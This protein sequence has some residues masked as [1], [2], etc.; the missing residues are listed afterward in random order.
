MTILELI[1]R[2]RL[3]VEHSLLWVLAALLI[4]FLILFK[5]SIDVLAQRLDIGYAPSLIVAIAVI[6]LTLNQLVLSVVISSL[7]GKNCDLA[8]KIAELEWQADQLREKM[9]EQERQESTVWPIAV[10]EDQLPVREEVTT[11]L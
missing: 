4:V 3:R 1:R 7:V 6:L 8:Q 5:D 10:E 11:L 2:R 9:R